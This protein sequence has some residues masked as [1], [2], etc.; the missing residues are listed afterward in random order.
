MSEYTCRVIVTIFMVVFA[1]ALFCFIRYTI[2]PMP[3]FFTDIPKDILCRGR[4]LPYTYKI[5]Y[6][7]NASPIYSN[8]E[9]RTLLFAYLKAR[10]M[11]L[12]YDIITSGESCGIGWAIK[13]VD[14]ED[15]K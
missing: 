2:H 6:F 11:A 9:Y 14:K 15:Q 8:K 13:D 3:N 1:I 12:K 10:R 5:Q 4:F 7:G